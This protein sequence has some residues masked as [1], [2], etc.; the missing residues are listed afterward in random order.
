MPI[1]CS[2]ISE[3]SPRP[4]A[5]SAKQMQHKSKKWSRQPRALLEH[6]LLDFIN[7]AC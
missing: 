6:S 3:V 7:F 5:P 2:G 4:K 1:S